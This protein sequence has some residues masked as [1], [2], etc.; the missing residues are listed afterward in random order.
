MTVTHFTVDWESMINERRL[1]F[2]RKLGHFRRS[3]E[4]YMPS[5]KRLVEE[6]AV[7]TDTDA[8]APAA[9]DVK[10]WLPSGIPVEQRK[11][12]ATDAMYKGELCLRKG[13]CTDALTRLRGKLLAQR[14]LIGFQNTNVVGQYMLM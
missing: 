14:F 10:L 12:V 5:V 4:S 1:T 7:D 9:E 13:Q 2:F 3:Q 6:V 8:P 11:E